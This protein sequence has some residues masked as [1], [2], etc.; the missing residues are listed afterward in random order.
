MESW[1]RRR[2]DPLHGRYPPRMNDPS[3]RRADGALVDTSTEELLDVLTSDGTPTGEA[4]ARAA[5]HRDGD[6]H[7]VFHLWIVKDGDAVLVQRRAPGKD[8]APGK[9]DVTVGGHLRAGEGWP[10]GLREVEEELGFEVDPTE[11]AHLGTFRNERTYPHAV[12]REFQEVFALSRDAPLD[13]YPLDP[14]EVDVLYELPLARAIELWRDGRH[15]PAAGWDAQR[16]V[17]D[18]LLYEADLIA[19]GRAGTVEALL[20]LAAWAGVAVEDPL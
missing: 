15:A 10:Q 2:P 5:V 3:Q 12:D 8:L 1:R 14:R 17:S 16:R 4:K 7:R 13:A 11:L 9:L 20:A 19:E 18:A 6:W